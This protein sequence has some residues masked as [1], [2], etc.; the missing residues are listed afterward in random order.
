MVYHKTMNDMYFCIMVK[1]KRNAGHQATFVPDEVEP[2]TLAGV[3]VTK[4]ISS[5]LL[6]S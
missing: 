2:D 6:F 1:M 4:P 3:G 5:V